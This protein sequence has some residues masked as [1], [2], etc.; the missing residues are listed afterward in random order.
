MPSF[1]KRQKERIEPGCCV[2]DAF[3]EG[4][5]QKIFI[6]RIEDIEKDM[7]GDFIATVTPLHYYKNGRW[8]HYEL[9]DNRAS[10]I[11]G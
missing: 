4:P 5:E 11:A 9:T 2:V 10:A 3:G 6:Y 8:I 1:K 7:T